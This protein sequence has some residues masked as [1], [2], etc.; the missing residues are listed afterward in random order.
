MSVPTRLRHLL[1]V[2]AFTAGTCDFAHAGLVNPSFELNALTPGTADYTIWDASNVPGWSTTATDNLIELWSDGFGGFASFEGSQHVELNAFQISTLYQDATGIPANAT[3]GFRFAH[4]GRTGVDVLRLTI[5][6]FGIDEAFGSSDDIVLFTQE[7]SDGMAWGLYQNPPSQ[8]IV[9]LGHTVRFQFISVSADGDDARIGNFIDDADFG[10]DIGLPACPDSLQAYYTFDDSTNRGADI[11]NGLDGTRLAATLVEGHC[12][13]ALRFRPDNNV[14]EFQVPSSPGLNMTGAMSA[15]AYIRVRGTQSTD[16]NPGCS[17]GTIF[18]KGGANWFQVERDNDRL[19]FQNEPSGSEVAVGFY[20]FPINEWTQ[21][22]FVRGPW[23]PGGQSIQFYVNC[24]TIPTVVY[25]NGVPTGT[26]LLHNAAF[27]SGDPLMVGNHGFGNSPE[28]C[29]FNGDIDELRF[30]NRELADMDYRAICACPCTAIADPCVEAD[31]VVMNTGWDQQM[32]DPLASHAAD[33]EWFVVFDPSTGLGGHPAYAEP[34]NPSGLPPMWAPP[35]PNSQWVVPDFPLPFSI[36]GG[37]TR[38]LEYRFCLSDTNG[39]A[40]SLSL[41]TYP[42]GDVWINDVR[43]NPVMLQNNS[44][45]NQPPSILA[46]TA[47]SLFRIGENVLA[48]TL[49]GSGIDVGINVVGSIH[50][51]MARTFACCSESTGTVTGHLWSDRNS[52]SERDANDPALVGWT[53]HMTGP[54]TA[55]DTTDATGTYCFPRLPAGTYTITQATP[56]G[57]DATYPHGPAGGPQ[58]AYQVIVDPEE[59]VDGLDF[60]RHNQDPAT[61]GDPALGPALAISRIHPNP[62]A[63]ATLIDFVLPTRGAPIVQI[64]DLVGRRVADLSPGALAAGAHSVI[65]NGCDDAGRR[66]APGVYVV[67]I[68]MG[69]RVVTRQVALVY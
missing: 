22:G 9:A 26:N 31:S 66:A 68:R 67:R 14:H 57:F 41:R 18:A 45:P 55:D 43:I 36:P 56:S 47:P 10:I 64:F 65:W 34:N 2:L 30:F 62:L 1:L 27:A 44:L 46:A 6:D 50:G 25:E 15:S 48:F 8:P 58:G 17:E 12:G 35:Q 32:N 29:E 7:Y 33:N 20:P 5:T 3:V 59:V 38:R 63:R 13:T 21:V 53:V 52:D 42:H 61:V 4:R 28:S 37:I 11:S 60:G 69:A 24:N 39:V 16:Y 23:T 51:P 49:D 54:V 19:V 40:V